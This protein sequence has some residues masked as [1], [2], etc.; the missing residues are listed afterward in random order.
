MV[1]Q[2]SLPPLSH[3]DWVREFDRYKQFPEYQQRKGMSLDEFKYIFWWE[4][5]HRMTGRFLG[6]AYGLPLLYFSARG[7]IPKTLYPR[8]ATLFALGGTQVGGAFSARGAT[9]QDCKG[10]GHA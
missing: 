4:Y 5:G 8:L 3:E 9:R 2:G 1:W 10:G 7:R 6:L